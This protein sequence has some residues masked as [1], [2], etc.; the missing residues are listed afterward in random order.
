MA[1]S[2]IETLGAPIK[3]TLEALP[4]TNFLTDDEKAL[5]NSG[6][7][8]KALIETVPDT[9]FMTDDEKSKLQNLVL[10]TY[11]TISAA[12]TTL[13]EDDNGKTVN[14]KGASVKTN[15]NSPDA[16]S[17]PFEITMENMSANGMR[18]T[19]PDGS[20]IYVNGNA[21][22]GSGGGYIEWSDVGTVVKIKRSNSTDHIVHSSTSGAISM[23]Q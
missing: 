19:V 3:A 17:S 14:N 5:L 18:Y 15:V 20:F 2:E 12:N 21:I 23:G 4:D 8:L 6:A 10:P 13:T 22:G 7:D 16:D 9:N 1:N 11:A